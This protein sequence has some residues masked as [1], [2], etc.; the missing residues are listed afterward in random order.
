[1]LE[2]EV[3]EGVGEVEVREISRNQI[4]K[5]LYNM[6]MSLNIQMK[7]QDTSQSQIN[8]SEFWIDPQFIVL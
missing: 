1:M 2:C 4:I 5:G 3:Q 8:I 6:Q 7:I